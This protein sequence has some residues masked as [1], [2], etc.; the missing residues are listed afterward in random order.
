MK[1]RNLLSFV[2]LFSF[3]TFAQK[4]DITRFEPKTGTTGSV[5]TIYG[6]YIGS[7]K[8]VRFG[9]VKASSFTVKTDTSL[10][11]VVG[12]GASGLI[13]VNNLSGEDTISY[14]TFKAVDTTP[15]VLSP[16]ISRFEPRS[17]TKG[18]KVYIFGKNLKSTIA[19]AFGNTIASSFTIVNDTCITAIVGDGATGDIIIKTTQGLATLGSF[20]YIQPTTI[21]Y[22]CDSIRNFIPIINGNSKD[23]LICFRDS[24]IKLYVS[25]G[26]FKSYR[27][28][29]GDTTP[30][31]YVSKSTLV[32]VSV[33]NSALG[34]SA[35]G[36]FSKPSLATKYVKNQLTQPT[37]TYK[38]SI[39]LSSTA[40]YYRWYFNN[41]LVQDNVSKIKATKIGIYW[42]STSTDKTCWTN[43]KEFKLSIGSLMPAAD[44]LGVKVYPNPTTGQFNVTVVLPKEQLAKIQVTITDAS[45]SIVYRSPAFSLT[46]REINIPLE[47]MKKGFYN[48]IV[49][50]NGRFKTQVLM[51]K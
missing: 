37:L 1:I 12:G 51:V 2:L 17:G 27:W 20:T 6:K 38:D 32:Y 31:I 13:Q 45:G 16:I 9:G 7:T 18:T 19:I 11:A 33:G 36:C 48:V 23:S 24:L 10:T 50:V 4:P 41:S 26:S 42:V 47:L 25:N 40:P 3:Q 44:S 30:V 35:T 22:N 15:I 43:S 14:F 28:S 8:I 34:N 29:T 49:E 39:L 5:I 46:G 21:P